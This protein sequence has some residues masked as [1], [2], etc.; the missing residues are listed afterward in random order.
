M[1]EIK[2]DGGMLP[3]RMINNADSGLQIEIEGH[4]NFFGQGLPVGGVVHI[5]KMDGV[6][7]VVVWSDI[8]SP[9]P[10]H[11]IPLTGALLA[12]F[13]QKCIDNAEPM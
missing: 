6:M 8:D 13:S 10:T 11:V 3:V 4:G 2:H 7:T 9:H 5:V 12:N 1:N